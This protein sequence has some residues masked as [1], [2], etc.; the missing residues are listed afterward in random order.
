[1][2]DH[3]AQTAPPDRFGRFFETAADML[4]IAD[5]DGFIR[6]ANPSWERVLGWSPA[7][8]SGRPYLD[9]VHPDDVA[10]TLEAAGALERGETVGA[11]PTATR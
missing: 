9:F 1:M 6:E 5:L 7:E 2:R 10:A 3:E 4:C 8:L 11:S